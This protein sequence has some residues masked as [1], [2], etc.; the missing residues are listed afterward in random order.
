MGWF[1]KLFARR[2]PTRTEHTTG[3]IAAVA[4]PGAE[5]RRTVPDLDALLG[6]KLQQVEEKLHSIPVVSEERARTCD[7]VYHDGQDVFEKP[8]DGEVMNAH[9]LLELVAEHTYDR[10]S[11]DPAKT[12]SFPVAADILISAVPRG[13]MLITSPLES[14]LFYVVRVGDDRYLCY[15]GTTYRRGSSGYQHREPHI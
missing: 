13:E 4:S 8:F 6:E 7:D 10:W 14:S 9:Q 11:H 3:I 2:H 12:P 15:V 5:A 1:E